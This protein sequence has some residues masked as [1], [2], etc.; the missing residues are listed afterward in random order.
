MRD[1]WPLLPR[2]AVLPWPRARAA[3]DALAVV[4]RA[5]RGGEVVDAGRRRAA[6][7]RGRGLLRASRGRRAPSERGARLRLPSRSLGRRSSPP[8]LRTASSP[9][10]A[11]SSSSFRPWMLRR[12]PFV[13]RLRRRC[14]T[15]RIIP[16]TAGESSRTTL[17]QR[18]G[19][20][21]PRASPSG[22][23]ACR[24]RSCTCRDRGRS[25]RSFASRRP[26]PSRSRR[27]ASGAVGAAARRGPAAWRSRPRSSGAA[28]PSNVALMT[29]CG[30]VVR[31][32]FVRMSWMPTDSSTARTGPPAMTPVP[33]AAGLSSTRPGA[34]ARR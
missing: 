16:R 18:R 17:S 2:P 33:G 26:C 20:R 19:T 27:S 21:G 23:S 11:S 13:V 30:F 15:F 31:S 6:T 1:F 4:G 25:L 22:P 8:A 9:P 7:A 34:V 12:Q 29:L 10:A 28:G 24:C 32:D 3:A 14:R 5:R